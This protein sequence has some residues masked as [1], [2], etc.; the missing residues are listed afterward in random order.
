MFTIALAGVVPLS[1]S[2]TTAYASSMNTQ[3]VSLKYSNVMVENADQ[4]DIQRKE[5]SNSVTVNVYDKQTGNLLNTYGEIVRPYTPLGI[6]VNAGEYSI[7]TR[8]TEKNE[9]G[10][11]ITRLE[12]Q[13][14]L[15]N[16]GSF[17]Q[18][19]QILSKNF[20]LKLQAQR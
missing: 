15:Y 3:T 8:F 1:F 9:G 18:I 7:M 13:L 19:N 10:G 2:S 4:V 16:S 20:L 6:S 5:T 12:L 14:Q 11:I 17:R